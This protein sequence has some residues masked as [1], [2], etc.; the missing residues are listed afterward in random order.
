MRKMRLPPLILKYPTCK[1]TDKASMTKMPPTITSKKLL[2]GNDRHHAQGASKG[3]R[4]RIAHEDLGRIAVE[5][6]KAQTGPDHGGAVDGHLAGAGDK[7][8]L[9]I[10]GHHRITRHIGEDEVGGGGDDNRP[11]GQSV[12][13]VGEIDGVGGTNDDNHRKGHIPPAQIWVNGLKKGQTEDTVVPRGEQEKNPHHQGAE[14]LQHQLFT[15][16]QTTRVALADF[17]EIIHSADAAK[18]EAD[19]DEQ[20]HQRVAQV[21]PQQGRGGNGKRIKMPPM[22]GTP[23]LEK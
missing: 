6:Q 8:D 9:Q 17:F 1:M 16:R 19:T 22:V 11:G 5:P 7:G 3:K 4:A 18:K 2:F 10:A 15:G 21:G 12:K 14:E 13:A 20:P 23:F